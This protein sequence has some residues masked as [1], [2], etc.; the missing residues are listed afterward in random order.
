MDTKSCE[1]FALQCGSIVKWAFDERTLSYQIRVVK[2]GDIQKETCCNPFN[3]MTEEEYEHFK[4][5]CP[6]VTEIPCSVRNKIYREVI[7]TRD[8]LAEYITNSINS[9]CWGVYYISQDQKEFTEIFDGRKDDE[10][11][12]EI[13]SNLVENVNDIIKRINNGETLVC[14]MGGNDFIEVY[15]YLLPDGSYQKL[16][17]CTIKGKK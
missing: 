15:Y 10:S 14:V 11:H 16:D 9:D 17:N 8:E 12:Q 1:E 4:S 6:V 5:L 2:E 7:T 13:R 3:T